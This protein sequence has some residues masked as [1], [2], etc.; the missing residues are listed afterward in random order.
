MIIF[1]HRDGHIY[2][3]TKDGSTYTSVTTLIK[4][5][6]N[7]FNADYWSSY[8]AL[9]RIIPSFKFKLKISNGK[10][11]NIIA[12]LSDTDFT[13]FELY[14]L[15][16]LADW[17]RGNE[18]AQNK[19]TTIHLE[20]ENNSYSSNYETNPFTLKPSLVFQKQELDY[21]NYSLCD[22]LY[23]LPDG[24]YPEL[25]IWNEDYKIAGQSDKVFIETVGN[26][27]FVDID[28][29]KTNKKINYS[30]FFDT[31]KKESQKMKFPLQDLMDCNSVH[32]SLQLSTYG[33]MLSQ[34]GFV[35]RNL[36]ITH[37][38]TNKNT[39]KLISMNYRRHEI[40]AIMKDL[41]SKELEKSINSFK[42]KLKLK[43]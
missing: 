1:S 23:D 19:G 39:E 3:N 20:K 4:K 9:E 8:K 29:Y 41:K 37:I 30:S 12:R 28:D 31:K 7:E 26:T 38:D 25:L 17:A 40:E 42:T 2:K 11:E 18:D 10:L 22:N 13:L 24:F 16:I 5:Y 6:T 35:V 21:D 32:Y 43:L 14:K 34:M 33:Y 15:E 36:A 27:R